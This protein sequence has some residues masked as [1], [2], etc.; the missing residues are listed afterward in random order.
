MSG[1]DT[2]ADV[3]TEIRVEIVHALPG[4]ALQLSLLLPQGAKI[5]DALTLAARSTEFGR[6]DLSSA[7]VGIFGKVLSRDT[8]LNEGDR[9]EIYRPLA[10]DP[11]TARRSRAVQRRPQNQ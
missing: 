11:K 2:R 3:G 6:L 10:A 1:A 7:P 9:I 4:A 8:L 5:E